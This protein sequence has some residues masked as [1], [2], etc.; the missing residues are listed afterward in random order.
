MFQPRAEGRVCGIPPNAYRYNPIPRNKAIGAVRDALEKLQMVRPADRPRFLTFDEE[1]KLKTKWR[2]CKTMKQFVRLAKVRPWTAWSLQL[3]FGE[4]E[5]SGEK[6][7]DFIR[8]AAAS[9]VQAVRRILQKEEV[10]IGIHWAS[11][12][13]VLSDSQVDELVFLYV[14]LTKVADTPFSVPDPAW[15]NEYWLVLR[16][17]SPQSKQRVQAIVPPGYRGRLDAWVDQ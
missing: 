12:Y 16:R 3:H 4:V 9:C 2:E 10:S 15:C 1:Q 14:E 13:S 5:D 8:D 11:H 7:E 6:L 17:I